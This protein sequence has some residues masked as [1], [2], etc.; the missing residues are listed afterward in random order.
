M[1][2]EDGTFSCR[3]N[4][5]KLD[6]KGCKKIRGITYARSFSMRNVTLLIREL[7]LPNA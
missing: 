7:S 3:P 6:L 5:R 2:D 4:M 1:Y